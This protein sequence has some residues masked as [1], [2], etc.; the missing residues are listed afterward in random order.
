PRHAP[1][2]VDLRSVPAALPPDHDD[3]VRS[4][5]RRGA[6]RD[7][8]RLR[9]GAAPA[10]R[11]SDHG[12]PDPV[13]TADAVHD[14]GRVSLPGPL[15]PVV[16]APARAALHRGSA[17]AM[18]LCSLLLVVVVSLAAC[19]A[20]PD[21]KKPDVATPSDFKETGQEWKQA[22]PRDEAD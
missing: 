11:Y 8:L 16:P 14:A 12:R 2:G 5:P 19:K 9:R 21:Y 15:P 6:A 10:A 17:D 13:A 22:Q 1:R 4:T 18:R 7:R 20:G 3:H